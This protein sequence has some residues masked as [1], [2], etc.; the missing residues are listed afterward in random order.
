MARQK[1]YVN[2]FHIAF[3]KPYFHIAPSSSI[4][5]NKKII[6]KQKII[7]LPCIF[8]PCEAWRKLE[9][10][11]NQIPDCAITTDK[12]AQLGDKL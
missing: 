12:A 7:P 10:H 4:N 6:N 9:L 8:L 11:Q 5:K 1:I 3:N 2:H